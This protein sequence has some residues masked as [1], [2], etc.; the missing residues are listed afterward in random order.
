MANFYIPLVASP[1]IGDNSGGGGSNLPDVSAA[2][3]GDVLTVVNGAWDKAAPSGGGG[4]LVVRDTDGTLDKT[5]QEIYDAML[6]GGAVYVYQNGGIAVFVFAGS[7][8]SQ[9]HVD[10]SSGDE[11]YTSTTDGYPVAQ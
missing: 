11:F 10:T 5:W 6:S 1:P 8:G 3:N 9:Y 7:N 2:D 4:V